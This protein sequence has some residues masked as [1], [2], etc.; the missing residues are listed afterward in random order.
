MYSREMLDSTSSILR[1]SFD[2]GSSSG[3]ASRRSG[4]GLV[5]MRLHT[6]IFAGR[7]VVD[8]GSAS[9]SGMP[10]PLIACFWHGKAPGTHAEHNRASLWK[11]LGFR[12][13]AVV[14][15]VA[16]WVQCAC[17]RLNIPPVN[18]GRRFWRVARGEWKQRRFLSLPLR[19]HFPDPSNCQGLQHASFS[20]VPTYR[21]PD[22]TRDLKTRYPAVVVKTCLFI[23]QEVDRVNF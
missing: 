9:L 17:V 20:H 3:K 8:F 16:L 13:V 10:T 12:E 6:P 7:G 19:L 1:C 11:C 5:I 21:V 14:F 18:R 2:K 15:L 22:R 23:V 4:L